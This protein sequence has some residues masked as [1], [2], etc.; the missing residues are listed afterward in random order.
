MV[1]SRVELV[2]FENKYHDDLQEMLKEFTLEVFD[3]DLLFPDVTRFV[4]GHS[5]VFIILVQN[6]A[7]GFISYQVDD[8]FGLKE[9]TLAVN[10]VY[11]K[12]GYRKGRTTFALALHQL[13]VAVINELPLVHHYA[14]DDSRAFFNRLDG[15]LLYNTYEFG[16]ETI[17]SQHDLLLNKKNRRK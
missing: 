17:K 11:L 12:E 15:K 8:Y 10:Y 6:K 1:R 14:S 13:E 2:K 4:G 7:V 9:P 16:L 3:N 5:A